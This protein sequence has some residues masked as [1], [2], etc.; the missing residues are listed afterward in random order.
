MEP[1]LVQLGAPEVLPDALE[2]A[3]GDVDVVEDGEADEEPRERVVHLLRKEHRNDHAVGEK[4][5]GACG[6]KKAVVLR[7]CIGF[8]LAVLGNAM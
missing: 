2:D 4:P 5:E 7:L 3:A 1:H 6:V 8:P